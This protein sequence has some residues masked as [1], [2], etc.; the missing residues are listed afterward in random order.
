[1]KSEEAQ[2]EKAELDK[3]FDNSLAEWPD[4]EEKARLKAEL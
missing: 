3:M 1:M 4:E 2:R